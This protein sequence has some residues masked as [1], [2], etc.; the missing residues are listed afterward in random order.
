MD[1]KQQQAAIAAGAWLEDVG[2]LQAAR[3]KEYNVCAEIAAIKMVES[4]LPFNLAP[5]A[6]N[7]RTSRRTE[8]SSVNR[9]H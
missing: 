6:R 2:R 8:I 9:I 7:E 3:G 5:A 4:Q 1:I